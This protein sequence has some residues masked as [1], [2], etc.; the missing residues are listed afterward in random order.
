MIYEYKIEHTPANNLR[1]LTEVCNQRGRE[2]WNIFQIER[3]KP[4]EKSGLGFVLMMK[5]EN[6]EVPIP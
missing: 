4:G 1:A 2:G 5:R 3:V 6:V